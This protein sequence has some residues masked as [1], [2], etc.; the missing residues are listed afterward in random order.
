M[1]TYSTLSQFNKTH[2]VIYVNNYLKE[3][4]SAL[5]LIKK[6]EINK[7]INVFP[8]IRKQKH[9]YFQIFDPLPNELLICI[10]PYCINISGVIN[11]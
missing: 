6:I 3:P 10:C 1:K 4:I 9:I 11:W 7:I 2:A 5:N 8:I